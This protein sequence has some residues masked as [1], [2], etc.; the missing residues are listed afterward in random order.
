MLTESHS[1]P[2]FTQEAGQPEIIRTA[3]SPVTIALVGPWGSGKTTVLNSIL[4]NSGL[5][6]DR[7]GVIFAEFGEVNVDAGRISD[8]RTVEVPNR[9]ICCHGAEALQEGINALAPSVDLL[10]IETSGVSASSNVRNVLGKMSL[11]FAVVG[12]CNTAGFDR[13]DRDLYDAQLP[14]ADF[15]LLTH[16]DWLGAD[17]SLNN[18]QLADVR[19]YLE[20]INCVDRS[21][22]TLGLGVD[23]ELLKKIIQ[24]AVGEQSLSSLSPVTEGPSSISILKREAGAINAAHHHQQV[25]S[26]V[27]HDSVDAVQVEAA[28]TRMSHVVERAKG[29][30]VDSVG[31]RRDV[32]YVKGRAESG[33]SI[34]KFLL[35]DK[36]SVSQ[37]LG[38]SNHMAIFSR[39]KSELLTH[40][41]FLSIGLPNIS[42]EK[43][44]LANSRYPVHSDYYAQ[45][46]DFPAYSHAGDRF[47]GVLFPIIKRIDEIPQDMRAAVKMHWEQALN[48]ALSW[49]IGGVYALDGL[50]AAKPGDQGLIGT[51]NLL[52][53]NLLWHF[54]NLT[55]YISPQIQQQL[56]ALGLANR[57]FSSMQELEQPPELGGRR[58]FSAD[59]ETMLRQFVQYARDV[60]GLSNSPIA[61][62]IRR[63]MTTDQSGTWNG[64]KELLKFIEG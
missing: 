47:Y 62:A 12:L 30:I 4:V 24:V 49:R 48:N 23:V 15:V 60:E 10:L 44:A 17:H 33:N 21:V 37:V 6:A 41:E 19:E 51:H 7:I 43:I 58:E 42:A 2:N 46:G 32:D 1:T 25:I 64:A 3:T 8:S 34:M 52:A 22:V 59:C 20:G 50:M 63:A 26:L 14:A 9:C 29:V 53:L 45:R 38:G 18:G 55:Q 56:A 16:T 39:D 57:F 40:A 28:L 61:G 31:I 35:S 36:P 11:S 13:R 27:L 54:T 5:S